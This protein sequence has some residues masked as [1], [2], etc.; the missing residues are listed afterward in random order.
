MPQENSKA[1][2]ANILLVI[3]FFCFP[4][5]TKISFSAINKKSDCPAYPFLLL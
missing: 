1:K 5:T 3:V 2:L 4:L